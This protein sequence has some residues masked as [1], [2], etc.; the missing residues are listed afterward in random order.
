MNFL[1]QK[2][3]IR[4]AIALGL[5][6]LTFFFFTLLRMESPQVSTSP[7]GVRLDSI[8]V[9]FERGTSRD[10]MERVAKSIGGTLV[11]VA[12]KSTDAQITVPA[13]KNVQE[14]DV[15][16]QEVEMHPSVDFAK[17]VTEYDPI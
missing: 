14:I 15:L 11:F 4:F 12:Y 7:N 16:I 3:V 13:Q 6:G 8:I 2:K 1:P 17:P 5:L 10:E 9:S